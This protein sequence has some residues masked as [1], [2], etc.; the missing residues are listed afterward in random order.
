MLTLNKSYFQTFKYLLIRSIKIKNRGLL[1]K[2]INSFI[3]SGLQ[4]I[5]FAFIMPKIGLDKN[6]GAFIV[7]ILPATSAF[8]AAMNSIYPLLSDITNDGSGLTYELIL[9]VP[10]WLIFTKYSLECAYQAFMA[11]VLILPFG[12]LILWNNF[13]FQYFS[14]IKF[15]FILILSLLFF[16]FFA[17]FITSLCKDTYTSLDNIWMRFIFTM[18][19]FG[20]AQFS[21]KTLYSVSPIISYISLL[22]PLLYTMEGARA[23]AL[24]PKLSFPYWLCVFALIFFTIIFGYIGIQNLK[25]RMDCL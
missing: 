25:R 16:G 24:D 7:A 4:I 1:D 20:G 23:A 6:F 9:P 19:F 13:S 2:I 17:L 18:W 21:W 22:N 10:Q 15:Y 3:W 12:K 8:F 14:F 11:S 5:L